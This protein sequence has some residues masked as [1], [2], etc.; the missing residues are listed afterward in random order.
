M[1]KRRNGIHRVLL[2]FSRNL[3]TLLKTKKILR[4]LIKDAISVIKKRIQDND[5]KRFQRR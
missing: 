5:S 2:E 3:C 4:D 1:V